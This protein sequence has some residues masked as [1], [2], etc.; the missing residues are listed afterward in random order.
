V[1]YR[2][3]L[4][5]FNGVLFWDADLQ[6]QSWQPIA[7]LLRGST[8][9]AHELAAHMHGRPNSDVLTY[10]AG[11][12]IHGPE[13]ADWIQRKEGFYRELCLENPA[14]FVLS[15]GAQTLLD[16]LK[17]ACIPRTIATSSEITNLRFFIQHL[18][19]EQWFDV[20]QIVYDDGIRPGKPAP[21]IYLEAARRIGL[22]PG[23]CV[24]V[25]D[26]VSGLRSAHAAGIGY[27]IGLGPSKR[28]RTL[29]DHPGVSAAIESLVQFPRRL[30][31]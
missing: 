1:K 6:V 19:L 4:F 5:D 25:E 3:I 14:S 7:Q 26:A 18:H 27:L 13:L 12:R 22:A 11:R 16:A 23:E 9:T 20:T 8:M 15:P 24:V 29:Q 17:G 21:D 28:H 30:L 2:G 10:L 31:M